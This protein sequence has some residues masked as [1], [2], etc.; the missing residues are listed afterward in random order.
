M[1]HSNGS[2]YLRDKT[3]A[4]QTQWRSAPAG[5]GVATFQY[6][7][8]RARIELLSNQLQAQR[9]CSNQRIAGQTKSHRA[10]FRQAIAAT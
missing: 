10:F 4:K 3:T 7:H 2:K 5:K 1:I 6:S 9:L 8:G